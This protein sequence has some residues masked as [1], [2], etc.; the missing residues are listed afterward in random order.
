M[1]SAVCVS[2]A[3]NFA[4]WSAFAPA[5][6]V[7]TAFLVIFFLNLYSEQAKLSLLGSGR[8]DRAEV[9]PARFLR[10]FRP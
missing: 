6:V 5:Q 2:G 10:F 7:V 8:N 3:P 4:D 1:C 9:R